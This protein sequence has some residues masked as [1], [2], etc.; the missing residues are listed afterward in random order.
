M[1]FLKEPDD[2]FSPEAWEADYQTNK[3]VIEYQTLS[4]RGQIS[5]FDIVWSEN[6]KLLG[7]LEEIKIRRRNLAQL[8]RQ[9]HQDQQTL[10]QMV[11]FKFSRS[12][13][14]LI[15]LIKYCL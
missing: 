12:G 9:H 10:L 7:E 14:R 8:E 2:R 3:E 1:E 15:I 13:L 11:R 6:N 4:V 5:N